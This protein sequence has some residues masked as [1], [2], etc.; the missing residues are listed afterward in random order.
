MLMSIYDIQLYG[1][2]S[3]ERALALQERVTEC[4]RNVAMWMRSNRLQLNAVKTN[5][6]C[7][8]LAVAKVNS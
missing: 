1:F 6:L 3:P 5:V 4:I 7:V 2:C 8:R